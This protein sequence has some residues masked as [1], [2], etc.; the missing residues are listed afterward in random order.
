MFSLFKKKTERKF[1]WNEFQLA[2]KYAS[3]LNL[4]R[5]SNMHSIGGF[6]VNSYSTIDPADKYCTVDDLYSIVRLL[7]KTCKRVP[8]YNYVITDKKKYDKYKTLSKRW[9]KTKRGWDDLQQLKEQSMELAG[10]SDPLQ[11]K[12]D[13]PDPDGC[14]TKDEFLE[15]CYGFMLL[16]GNRYIWMDPLKEGANKGKPY[17]LYVL[18]SAFT[19]PKVN[20]GFPPQITGYELRLD[21]LKQISKDEIIHS[22]YFNPRY[23]SAG[24]QLIGLSPVQVMNKTIT[25]SGAEADYTNQGFQNAGAF[26]MVTSPL[27]GID[28]DE[29]IETA[30]KLKDDFYKEVGPRFRGDTN[31]NA[32]RIAMMLGDWKYQ[33]FGF[34]PA[35][36]EVIEQRKITV[37]K[38][39]NGFGF[40]DRLLNNDA[41]GS[42]VSIVAMIKQLYTNAVFPEVHSLRDGLN[43]KLTPLYGPNNHID[44]DYTDIAEL[45]E[46]IAAVIKRFGEAPA[47]RVNDLYEAMGFGRLDD[48]GADAVLIKSG[49]S[50]LS[51]IAAPVEDITITDDYNN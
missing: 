50:L 30:G 47:F 48:E 19:V 45:Q 27:T 6:P 17:G 37:K 11:K 51:D 34:S 3:E 46:D 29:A 22:K 35:D 23:D 13:N 18:P 40:S 39:C 20:P 8:L 32:R 5:L 2:I 25:Q 4:G 7:V 43:A 12:L 38:M 1:T 15:A 14:Y 44:Y 31:L 10:D 49:Y 42:E 21:G 28:A 33:Q 9:D 16:T 26:G 41:T 36:M 24:S